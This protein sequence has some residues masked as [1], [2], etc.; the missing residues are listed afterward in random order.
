M[1]P[2]IPGHQLMA[3]PFIA[4]TMSPVPSTWLQSCVWSQVLED[5][6]LATTRDDHQVV[7]LELNWDVVATYK[8][9]P[10]T[11]ADTEWSCLVQRDNARGRLAE[12][13]SSFMED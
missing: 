8:R 11:H 12:N 13:C 4:L 6:D 10:R 3:T 9:A 2:D 1:V 7:G 5:F